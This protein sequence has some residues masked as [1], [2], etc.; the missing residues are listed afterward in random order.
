MKEKIL[1]LGIILVCLLAVS[2]ETAQWIT[3]GV[4]WGTNLILG[5]YLLIRYIHQKNKEKNEKD[6]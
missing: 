1:I 4:L 3:V 5:I 2:S 6:Y